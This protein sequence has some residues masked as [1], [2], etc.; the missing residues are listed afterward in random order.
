[1]GVGVGVGRCTLF[2][3]NSDRPPTEAQRLDWQAA[4]APSGPVR[5]THIEVGAAGDDTL[6]VLGSRPWW[7]WGFEHG[8]NEAGVAVG[9]ETIYTTLDPRGYPPALT[10]MDLVRLA[11]SRAATAKDCVG[12]IVDLI[13]QYGQGGTGHVGVERPYWSSF[14]VA[15]G[16]DAWVVETSGRTWAVEQVERTRAISN[17]TTI[18]DFDATHRHPDQPVHTLVDPRLRASE[19][20]LAAE[21]VTVSSLRA[22]ARSHEGDAA[23][24]FTVCM[25]AE[26]I[27]ATT[28]AIVAE[29]PPEGGGRPVAHLLLGSPCS[30]VFVPHVVGANPGVP[31]PWER[32]AALHP[33]VPEE[34]ERLDRLEQ[35]LAS[36]LVDDDEWALE[37][38]LRVGGALRAIES[39]RR[40]A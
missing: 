35:S 1:M 32:F 22:H 37:A 8:L 18:A 27:E 9:N 7:C 34:R 23:S 29:L 24:G 5:A 38:W 14:L 6:G 10:G 15:D 3:K 40:G 26:G 39:A 21:P 4:A 36:D 30:S 13:E 12:V 28:A 20:V 25:H 16:A 2:A 19:A 33:L 11:L 31:T 17:R